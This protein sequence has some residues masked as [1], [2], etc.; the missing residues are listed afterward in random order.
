[1]ATKP[2][3]SSILDS[4]EMSFLRRILGVR[5]F[6][7]PPNEEVRSRCHVEET[8]SQ[9]IKRRRLM[10]LG[11]VLRMKDG[12]M[13]Q[14]VLL[15]RH[16]SYWKRPR[17]RLCQSWD[18]MVN[19]ETRSLTD[20]IR[21]AVGSVLDWSVDGRQWSSYLG[22]LASSRTQWRQIVVELSRSS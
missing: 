13:P 6:P 4:C 16:P 15:D 3:H 9:I 18:R 7:Y 8:I 1:M 20:H 19:T 22:D 12:R 2:L 11:H 10:W 21:N 17:E 14:Q 5:G